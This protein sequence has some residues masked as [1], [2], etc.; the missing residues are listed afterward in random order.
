TGMSAVRALRRS[1]QS[2]AARHSDAAPCK[3]PAPRLS[4]AATGVGEDGHVRGTSQSPGGAAVGRDRAPRPGVGPAPRGRCGADVVHRLRDVGGVPERTL[5]LRPLPVAVLLAGTLRHAGA[6][7]VRAEARLVA[8]VAALLAGAPDP[9]GAR[10]LPLH[11]LLLP[12]RL[13]Q[14]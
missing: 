8:E 3:A 13:L 10:R 6:Q 7:L 12:R 11:L 4:S 2:G 1:P 5:H 9:V 14:G